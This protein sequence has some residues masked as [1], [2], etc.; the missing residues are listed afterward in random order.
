MK[1][2]LNWA[3]HHSN[4]DL[5]PN[6]LDDL[7]AK[8]GAQLGAVEEVIEYGQQYEGAVVAKVVSCEKHPNA[9]KLS[10][11]LID[12]GGVTPNVDRNENGHVQVVCGAPN[13]RA[14]A[15]V[16][17][18]PP[19]A[20]VPS[21]Y[22][23]DPF[24]LGAREL[25][26]VMSN[27]MLASAQELAISDSHDGILIIEKDVQPGTPIKD[28]FGLD[29][30]IIDIENKM[31]THRPDCF[32]VLGVAR[33]IAGIY[34]QEFK[35]P[36]WYSELPPY[37]SAEGLPIK[38]HNE[39]PDLV[40]RFITVT[41]KDVVIKPSP[42]WLQAGL[43]RVG[44][45][46]I[47]NIV[48]I[49]NYLAYVTAQPLHAYDYDKVAAL[50]EDGASLV[51]RKPREGEQVA[52][53]NGKTIEPR[54]E[55]IMIATDKELIGIG[56]VMG[57]S[58]TEVD[59]NTKNIII[60]CANFDM[61][62]IRRTSMAHGLF[63]DAVTRN[64]KGQSPLQNARVINKAIE[65]VAS[66]AGGAQASDVLDILNCDDINIA[67]DGWN[68]KEVTVS[69][70]FI[71][72]RLGLQLSQGE[73]ITLLKN[74][75]FGHDTK[76]DAIT[77]YSPF[78]R[79]DIAI[80]EDI[81]EEVGRLYGFDK[82]SLDLPKQSAAPTKIDQALALKQQI[83]STL[84]SFGANETLNYSFVH[85][86]LIEK[87][88]QSTDYAFKLSNAISPDL[89]YY[90]MSLTP[91][92][93]SVVHPNIKAGHNSFALFEIN[94]THITLHKDDDAGLPKEIS[95]VTLV[96]ADKSR[97]DA[98]YY[99]ARTYLDALAE[100]LGVTLTYEAIK[101]PLDY[102][103]TAPFEHTRSALVSVKG[104]DIF[105]GIVG[106]YKQSV[107]K[108]LKLPAYCAGFEIDLEG[109]LSIKPKTRYTPLSRYPSISQDICLEVDSSLSYGA[110]T[111][112]VDETLHSDLEID[113]VIDFEPIDIYKAK[114]SDKKR[115]TYRVTL[116]SYERTL[117]DAVLSKILD[118]VAEKVGA[119]RI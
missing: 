79:T 91:S 102:Q 115:I 11:C 56:G 32:G 87:A 8:I 90:R 67:D 74:V 86:N 39:L 57:G 10:V 6:G 98:A 110:L 85:G 70:D 15:L 3:Q 26:G 45:K 113:Q 96:V 50:S 49:T 23:S 61:Y 109:L 63:T 25:R 72:S 60:E 81:V 47:N 30:V 116:T 29:D 69:N 33:E 42:I 55:A 75:E 107:R 73:I 106:E 117:T 58:S 62:S 101:E 89:Q 20:T 13:V 51:V 14:D 80:K 94:K 38:V 76:E 44:I 78:W 28:V 66:Q 71:N 40:P 92:L 22:S 68:D 37:K 18:L 118:P 95:M 114:N 12:D 93:L 53:L 52:L 35:S 46:P 99:Q 103:V 54:A 59:E 17:W 48:D 2:S 41:M 16:V 21:T 77:F 27:G 108:S 31:F 24:V 36:D 84:A 105:L 82:L 100:S 64:N 104:T 112:K 83:R 19:G 34:G 4:V 43:T 119:V 5:K 1:V 65:L 111:T 88:G 7:I 9:D 97:K